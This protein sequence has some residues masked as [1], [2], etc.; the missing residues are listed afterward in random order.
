MSSGE[1]ETKA[2]TGMGTVF[3][4]WSGSVWVP[5]AE[6]LDINGPTMSRPT[7]DTTSLSVPGG[8]AIFI[9]GLRNPGTVVI[10]M[11]MSYDRYA[12]F[13]EDFE[14]DDLQSY[15]IE[16]PDEEET[17]LEFLA[18]VTEMPLNVPLADKVTLNITF[19]VSGPVA[20]SSGASS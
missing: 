17:T 18:L 16:L 9:G 4:R 6:V 10:T 7:V 8:Y 14:S 2:F 5:M 11:I 20:L 15:Q 12:A 3:S 13:L 1:F 19:Q